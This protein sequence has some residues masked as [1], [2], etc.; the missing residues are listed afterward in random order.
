MGGGQR[1]SL[2]LE[3]TGLKGV[4]RKSCKL[5]KDQKITPWVPATVWVEVGIT[6]DT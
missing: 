6:D 5:K 2:G 1:E 3:R 4:A